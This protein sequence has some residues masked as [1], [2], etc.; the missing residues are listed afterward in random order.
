M[1]KLL[2]KMKRDLD[3][4][5]PS[6]DIVRKAVEDASL[7]ASKP[8]QPEL[9]GNEQVAYF[10]KHRE[11]LPGFL[12]TENGHDIIYLLCDAFASYVEECQ[13]FASH[14]AVKS[15]PEAAA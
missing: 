12:A 4:P 11:Y 7:R 10:H 9:L 5:T 13:V 8:D 15:D 6:I 1:D 14:A 2:E 3:K